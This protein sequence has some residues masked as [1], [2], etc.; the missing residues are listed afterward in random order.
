MRYRYEGKLPPAEQ[1]AA[2]ARLLADA[3]DRILSIAEREQQHDHAVEL[4]EVELQNQ[5]LT[6]ERLELE[7]RRFEIESNLKARMLE[8]FALPSSSRCSSPSA[9]T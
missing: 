4:A 3:P 8:R 2:W 6:N 9:R 5:L 7:T 1:A